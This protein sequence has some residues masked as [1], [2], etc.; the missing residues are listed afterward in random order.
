MKIQ[1]E[2]EDKEK[3][4]EEYKIANIGYQSELERL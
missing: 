1:K 2:L 4:L 3:E